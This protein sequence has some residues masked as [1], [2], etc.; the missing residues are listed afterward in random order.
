MLREQGSIPCICAQPAKAC[1][2]A[3]VL[4]IWHKGG[5]LG[6]KLR[7]FISAHCKRYRLDAD[8]M[9]PVSLGFWGLQAALRASILIIRQCVQFF[10]FNQGTSE[11]KIF[12]TL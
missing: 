4:A 11:N 8:L 2:S 1:M 12:A 10:F 5:I 3:M 6:A 9:Q 7:A